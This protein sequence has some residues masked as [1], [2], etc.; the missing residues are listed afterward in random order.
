MGPPEVIPREIK[1]WPIRRAITFP[2]NEASKFTN[3]V[4]EQESK[5]KRLLPLPQLLTP[6]Q[7]E[8]DIGA[9]LQ[10]KPHASVIFH[11]SHKMAK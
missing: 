6:R 5:F 3:H 8:K 2:V 11:A 4:P 1:N 7:L 9:L 10:M